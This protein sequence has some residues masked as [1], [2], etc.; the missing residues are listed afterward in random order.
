MTGETKHR[1][2]VSICMSAYN[3]EGTLATTLDSLMR[4]TYRDFELILLDNG[5]TDGTATVVASIRDPRVRTLRVATNLGGYQGMNRVVGEARGELVAIYHADDVYEPNIVETEVA[6]LQAHPRVGAVM[7]MDYF[8]DENGKRF[9]A[10]TLP[11]QFRGR[12]YLTYADVF[13]FL[14]RNKNILFCC[15]TFMGRRAVMDAVGPFAPEVFDIGSDEEYYLRII[16]EYPIAVLPDRLVSYRV[17]RRQWSA[18]YERLRTEEERHFQVV[19][20][21]MELDGWRNRLSA[22]DLREYAFHRC[23]DETTRAANWLIKGD[24]GKARDLLGRP[25]AW[26]TFLVNPRRRKLRVMLLRALMRL[27]LSLGTYRSLAQ[28]LIRTEY[29]GQLA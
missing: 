27:G 29:G 28:V 24:V 9:G 13:P 2:L 8:I 17:S 19:E 23:D 1:P 26:S 5:S 21:Y 10:A 7:S 3:A 14:V 4:Q 20:H 6:Y 18:R 15:P 12:E 11:A 16:R 22:S 25:H